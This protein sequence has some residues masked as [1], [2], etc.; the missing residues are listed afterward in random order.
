MSSWEEFYSDHKA[1][2]P[3][4]SADLAEC[5]TH[6][7]VLRGLEGFKSSLLPSLTPDTPINSLSTRLAR[8]RSKQSESFR[9]DGFT[10]R[11][12]LFDF[13]SKQ[14]LGRTWVSPPFKISQE[15]KKSFSHL[16]HTLYFQL[17]TNFPTYFVIEFVTKAAQI[18]S[19]VFWTSFDPFAHIHSVPD[20]S[21]PAKHSPIR[22]PLFYGSSR[23]LFFLRSPLLDSRSPV[24]V[25]G[26]LL[27]CSLARHRALQCASHL[28]PPFYLLSSASLIPGLAY[29]SRQPGKDPFSSPKLLDTVPCLI[30]ELSVEFSQDFS[31]LSQTLLTTLASSQEI[32][33]Q[34]GARIT[35]IKLRV[36]IHNGLAFVHQPKILYLE[37]D[38]HNE[39]ALRAIGSLQLDDLINHPL[40]SLIFQLD[41]QIQ[42]SYNQ[43]LFGIAIL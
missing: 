33:A 25:P 38:R 35:E 40:V 22:I 12:H 5:S 6:C 14:F 7:L 42:V 31:T 21:S 24:P 18:D 43:R 36:G 8:G 11:I 16:G 2:L 26:C 13:E 19:S 28:F 32:S 27:I 15:D 39:Q 10:I 34:G 37:R 23:A 4:H 1:S 41:I 17:P 3:P 20:L 29:P 30:S 9:M